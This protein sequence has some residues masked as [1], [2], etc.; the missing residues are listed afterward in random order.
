M[1]L[2]KYATLK[3]KV[4]QGELL[5]IKVPDFFSIQKKLVVPYFSKKAADTATCIIYWLHF[6]FSKW[7]KY[8]KSRRTERV[9]FKGPNSFDKN[10]KRTRFLKRNSSQPLKKNCAKIWDRVIKFSGRCLWSF[11][12]GWALS[13]KMEIGSYLMWKN[14]E[15]MYSTGQKGLHEPLCYS[16]FETSP[17]S[18]IWLEISINC[19]T[20]NQGPKK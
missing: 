13:Y 5:V 1:V 11:P 17:F 4:W 3:I 16:T 2:V 20:K 7:V 9:A 10:T 15:S 19:H 12:F 6:F 8:L 14:F 18:S